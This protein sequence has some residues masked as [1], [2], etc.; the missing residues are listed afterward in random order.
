MGWTQGQVS[1]RLLLGRFL[2]FITTGNK[3]FSSPHLLTKRRFRDHWAKAGKGHAKE[4]EAD[5]FARVLKL[6]QESAS[7]VPKN[8][9]NLV[10]KPGIK[11][12]VIEALS[13]GKRLNLAGITAAVN[14]L[15]PEVEV[16]K[17]Q[18]QSALKAIQEKAPQGMILGAQHHGNRHVYKLVTSKRPSRNGPIPH[19]DPEQ[20]GIMAVDA[21]PLIN[22]CIEIMQHPVVGRDQST[23]LDHLS[24]VRQMLNRLLVLEE[25]V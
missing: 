1:Q 15:L 8:Y 24:R 16:D 25:V 20:A 3:S 17:D 21:L 18:V 4:T 19:V 13:A 10:K 2:G 14:E 23:A 7:V 6:L 22:E 5:R 9:G 11:K 12:A